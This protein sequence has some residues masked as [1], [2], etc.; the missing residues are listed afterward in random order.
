MWVIRVGLGVYSFGLRVWAFRLRL[1]ELTWRKAG[2]SCWASGRAVEGY[3]GLL[4]KLAC[5]LLV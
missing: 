2:G 5:D 3:G 4:Q 1:S